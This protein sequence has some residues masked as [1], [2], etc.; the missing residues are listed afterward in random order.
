M[1]GDAIANCIIAIL[2]HKGQ[3][4]RKIKLSSQSFAFAIFCLFS[5][6]FLAAF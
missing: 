3:S 5:E 1:E 2:L 6:L 4:F